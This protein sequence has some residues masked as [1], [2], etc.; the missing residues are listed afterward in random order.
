ML[1][2]VLNVTINA[3]FLKVGFKIY[4]SIPHI[5]LLRLTPWSTDDPHGAWSVSSFNGCRWH[6]PVISLKNNAWTSFFLAHLAFLVGLPCFV[7]LV[8]SSPPTPAHASDNEVFVYGPSQTARH[9]SFSRSYT[10]PNAPDNEVFHTTR[11]GPA[12]LDLVIRGM[13]VLC[14]R[15]VRSRKLRWR[16]MH[17]IITE[18]M[19][20]KKWPLCWGLNSSLPMRI[21][22]P[23]PINHKGPW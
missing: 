14:C 18:K 3:C 16:N 4:A 22:M 12:A 7:G 23:S 13:T 15:K 2:W 6:S 11:L 10:R 9:F 21:L 5:V 17:C 19:K 20:R 1:Q 8:L